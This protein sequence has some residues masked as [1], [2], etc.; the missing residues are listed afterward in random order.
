[1]NVSFD[2]NHDGLAADPNF[3]AL[4]GTLSHQS[5]IDS[6]EAFNHYCRTACRL[7]G[8]HA[9]E[10]SAAP[11]ALF[12]ELLGRISR[13]EEGT[14]QTP[15]GGVVVVLHQHP[16][17]EKYLVVRRGGYLALEKHEEKDERLEVL[18]GAGLLLGRQAAGQP[19]KVEALAPG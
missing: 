10:A 17:V 9:G 13:G 11:S 12:S 1:M 18:E 8:E 14:I 7:W 3:R 19:L 4:A 15:W 6:Q 16:A 5:R 2:L